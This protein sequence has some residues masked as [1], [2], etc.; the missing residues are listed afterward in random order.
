MSFFHS[1]RRSIEDR[2]QEAKEAS[3][4]CRLC[5]R[6]CGAA[7]FEGRYGFCVA[8]VHARVYRYAPHF[9]EEPPISGAGGS[10]TIFF[11]GCALRCSYC[12]NHPFSQDG[13][14]G[15]LPFEALAGVFLNIQEQG[16][17]NVNLVTPTHFAFAVLSALGEARRGGFKLPVVY[18]SGG[19]ESLETLKLFDGVVDIYLADMKYGSPEAAALYSGAADYPS[20][21]R[22]AIKEMWRQVGPLAV[23]GSGV[24]VR[25]LIVR[26]LVLPRRI[27]G[28]ESVARYLAE[29]VS[30]EATVSLM[31]QYTPCHRA[32]GD[33]LLSR[34]IT[35]EE[36][37]EARE[38][39]ERFGLTNGWTQEWMGEGK[40]AAFLGISMD[41]NVL[42]GENR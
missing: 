13:E 34:R 28:T 1:P 41:G 30:T 42:K 33:P 38:I 24:A 18:N 29:E 12:Q 6:R 31:S 14:G 26:H 21:N 23:D 9:G 11:G 10:G 3:D 8:G 39:F 37:E 22:A 5:P 32:L 36:Y 25:G 40:G 2:I 35:R 20:I 15:E 27:A 19:Y 4:P 7:R 16:C 17:H